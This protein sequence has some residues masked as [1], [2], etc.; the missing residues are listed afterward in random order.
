MS[1]RFSC[2]DRCAAERHAIPLIIV[3]HTIVQN[4][5]VLAFQSTGGGGN[6]LPPVIG[7][8]EMFSFNYTRVIYHL[9]RSTKRSSKY[10]LCRPRI[11]SQRMTEL[12]KCDVYVGDH[13]AFRISH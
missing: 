10:S 12:Q 7:T 3:Y 1:N 5:Y 9:I 8:R 2:Q 6:Q 13:Y 11:F 4:L